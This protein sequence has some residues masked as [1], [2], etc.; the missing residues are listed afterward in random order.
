M[1]SKVSYNPYASNV[2]NMKNRP[3]NINFGAVRARL[4]LDATKVDTFFVLVGR[5]K[6][7]AIGVGNNNCIVLTEGNAAADKEIRSLLG[8]N[9]SIIS[10]EE[11]QKNITKFLEDSFN[12][13][14]LRV[15]ERWSSRN[16]DYRRSN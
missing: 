16:S 7:A 15:Q 9:A 4:P 8:D 6:L 3:Q 12:E 10:D 5:Y 11:G 1:I 13:L 14:I 2:S